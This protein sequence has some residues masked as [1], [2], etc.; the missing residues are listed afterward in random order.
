ME[1][2]PSVV[3]RLPSLSRGAVGMMLMPL[4]GNSASSKPVVILARKI[5]VPP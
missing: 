2:P 3:C 4:N 1:D 5:S